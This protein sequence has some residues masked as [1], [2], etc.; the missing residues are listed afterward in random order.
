MQEIV[1]RVLGAEEEARARIERARKKA[2]E[3]RAAADEAYAASA[4]DA[5]AK[6]Q[7]EARRS[8]DEARAEAELAAE[9][10]REASRR[11]AEVLERSVGAAR[12]AL[13]EGMIAVLSGPRGR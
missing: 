12:E 6:A 10:E 1:E 7:A 5:R 9:R 3:I 4:S 11:R 8:L 2:A 13:L